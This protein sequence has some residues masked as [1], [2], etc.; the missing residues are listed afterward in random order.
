MLVKMGII[1]HFIHSPEPRYLFFSKFFAIFHC[2]NMYRYH[3]SAGAM[4]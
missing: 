4:E 2:G 3:T 1:S